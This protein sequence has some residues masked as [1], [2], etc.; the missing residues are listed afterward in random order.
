MRQVKGVSIT[1]ISKENG[2][3]GDSLNMGINVSK[4]PY[5]ICIDADSV[6]EGFFRKLFN[7]L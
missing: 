2:G 3:K 6:T 1:L 5:F 7:L 4:F